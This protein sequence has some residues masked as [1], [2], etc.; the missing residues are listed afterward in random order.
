MLLEYYHNLKD[1]T[2]QFQAEIIGLY[3][4]LSDSTEARQQVLQEA[5]TN[6]PNLEAEIHGNDDFLTI[7]SLRLESQVHHSLS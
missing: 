1:R 2:E 6:L 7:S 4:Q 3:G 5:R